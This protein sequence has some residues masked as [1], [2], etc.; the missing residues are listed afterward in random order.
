MKLGVDFGTTRIVVAAVDRG[1]Y[2]VLSFETPEGESRDWFPPVVAVRGQERRYGFEAWHAQEEPGWTVVRSLK[3]LLAEA[4]LD[5]TLE[6]GGQVIGLQTLLRE[7]AAALCQAV[8]ERSTLTT[9]RDEP[10]EVMLGVPANANSNQRFLTA[11]GFRQA[12]ARVLGMLNEPSAASIEFGH[13]S[14][15]AGDTARRRT[16]LVYDFGGGTFDASLV[17]LDQLVHEVVDSEGVSSVGGDDFDEVLADL[18]LDQAGIPLDERDSLADAAT[19]SP[20]RTVPHAQGGASSQF[21]P[22]RARPGDRVRS[23]AHRDHP[24]GGFLRPLSAARGPHLHGHRHAPSPAAG[25]DRP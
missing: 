6:L 25:G 22:H 15:A 7:M 10:F 21:T 23:M 1:N 5:T 24:G 2:P 9:R 17:E 4:G 13:G 14:R 20:L 12:G 3:R 18:A 16:V 11:E 8:R 19:F